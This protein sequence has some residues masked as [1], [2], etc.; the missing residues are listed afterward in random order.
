MGSWPGMRKE[1]GSGAEWVLMQRM[2]WWGSDFIAQ[3]GGGD[4]V[5]AR[6]GMARGGEVYGRAESTLRRGELTAG[7]R[8]RRGGISLV[9]VRELARAAGLAAAHRALGV[10]GAVR[11]VDEAV[12]LG[13]GSRT[14]RRKMADEVAQEVAGYWC[15]FGAGRE[16]RKDNGWCSATTGGA[17]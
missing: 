9:W 1:W 4:N 11:G 16:R 12:R 17:T 13:D 5:H 8:G 14:G 6:G 3:E 7:W 2:A 15:R 10:G